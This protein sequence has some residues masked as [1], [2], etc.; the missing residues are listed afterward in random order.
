MTTG[1]VLRKIKDICS[2]H[3]KCLDCPL[4]GIRCY[5]VPDKWTNKEIEELADIIDNYNE[6]DNHVDQA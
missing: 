4:Y 1:G 6:E 2:K 3:E 5:I